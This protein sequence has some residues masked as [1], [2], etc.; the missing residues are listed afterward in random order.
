VRAQV[1][2]EL[3]EFLAPARAAG[4]RAETL[5]TEGHVSST[6]LEFARK[7]P[8]DLLV[9]GT[10]GQGGL[11]RLVLGSVTESVLRKAPC[12]VLTARGE[13][14]TC[15]GPGPLKRILCATDF[16]PAADHALAYALSMAEEA[17]GTLTLVHVREDARPADATSGHGVL[18]DDLARDA[19]RLRDAVSPQARLWCETTEVVPLGRPAEEIV[20]LAREREAQVI[21][22]GVHGRN[23]LDLM[24]FGSTSHQVIRTAPCPVLIIPHLRAAARPLAAAGRR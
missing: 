8:A 7:Q 1:A 19:Q 23:V 3:E 17:Q 4:I 13:E 18:A 22:M 20:R 12:P 14:P 9:M 6:I 15:G 10:H 16:S 21:V 5:I 11:E 24:L 2:R